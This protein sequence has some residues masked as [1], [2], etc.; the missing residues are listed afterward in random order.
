[1]S[2]LLGASANEVTSADTSKAI[3]YFQRCLEAELP[4]F[5][6][7]EAAKNE[8]DRLAKNR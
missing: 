6:E 4:M 8:L 1:M 5:L 2:Y 7:Y 3:S